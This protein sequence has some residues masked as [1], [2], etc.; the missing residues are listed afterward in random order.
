MKSNAFSQGLSRLTIWTV[1]LTANLTATGL[2]NR[3]FMPSLRL[4]AEQDASDF[5]RGILD[6]RGHHMAVGVGSQTDGRMSENFHDDP[7]R[8][9]LGE[10][11]ACGTMAQIME[12]DIRQAGIGEHRLE[13]TMKITR[14]KPRAD[15]RREYET[16]IVPARACG[17]A[18]FELADAM[19]L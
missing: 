5:R 17:K 13:R 3:G 18:L 15:V 14:L 19:S 9:A 8:D 11:Q 2:Q 6:Q 10:H 7:E 16:T 1:G 4:R 12:A